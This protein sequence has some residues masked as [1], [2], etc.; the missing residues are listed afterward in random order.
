MNTSVIILILLSALLYI[1]GIIL[2]YGLLNDLTDHSLAIK[3]KYNNNSLLQ[4]SY[5]SIIATNL[6]LILILLL[7][8]GV[9]TSINLV[10]NGANLAFLYIES[11]RRGMDLWNFLILTLPHGI[12]EIPAII[13]AGAAGFKIPYEII[14][15]LVGKKETILTKEDVKEYLTLALISIIL[16]VI[17][18]WIEANITLKMAKSMLGRW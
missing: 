16:I 8:F 7:G 9:V 11:L 13:I 14:R 5:Q 10:F 6:N 12:F 15:Y 3:V 1:F 4:F 2:G 18:A 17:A